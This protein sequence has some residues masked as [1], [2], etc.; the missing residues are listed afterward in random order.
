MLK[1]F[2]IYCVLASVLLG[3]TA[4]MPDTVAFVGGTVSIPIMVT[5]AE[6]VEGLEFTIQYNDTVLTAMSTSFENTELDGLNFNASVGLDISDEIRVA[7]F[8]GGALYTVSGTLIFV[9]FDVIGELL[10]STDLIFTS[11]E[12]N[13]V[14]IVENAQNG[15]VTI[16]NNGCTDMQACNYNDLAE[17]DDGSCI[18]VFDCGGVCDGTAIIDCAGECDGEAAEDDCGVCNGNNNTM[19]CSGVCEGSAIVDCAGEC[20]CTQTWNDKT[21]HNLYCILLGAAIVDECGVCNG[22]CDEPLANDLYYSYEFKLSPNYPNPFNPT[23]TINYS[24]ATFS[25][26]NILIYSMSGELIQTIMNS[27]QQPGQYSVK[28]NASNFP[29]GLYFVKLISSN[30]IAEQKI[31]LIK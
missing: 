11:I 3:Q 30:K 26:V 7:A 20:T 25:T 16:D 27:S 28:W 17:I 18:Y 5:N 14:S 22:D 21:E 15:S 29:S 1:L 19:D 13:N 12:I 6:T 23:T 31:L 9:N 24:T 10:D 4:S 2:T 8:A